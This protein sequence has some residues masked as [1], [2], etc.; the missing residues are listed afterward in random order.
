MPDRLRNSSYRSLELLCRRQAVLSSSEE[1]RKELEIMANEY[2]VLADRT[3]R[4]R[5]ESDR[6]D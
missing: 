3:D 2:A 4:E 1:T 5:T 6:S